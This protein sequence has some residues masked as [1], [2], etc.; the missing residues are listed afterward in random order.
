MHTKTGPVRILVYKPTDRAT[1]GSY[2]VYYNIHGGGWTIAIPEWDN[3][4][5]RRIADETG[6]VVISIDYC[7]APEHPYPEALNQ[8]YEVL[9]WIADTSADGGAT[10][11]SLDPN[12]IAIGGGSAG[13]NLTVPPHSNSFKTRTYKLS[14]SS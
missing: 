2:P 14:L 5:C 6:A 10:M 9:R 12:R 7:K 11:L 3:F 1:S 13:G 4:W 8:C